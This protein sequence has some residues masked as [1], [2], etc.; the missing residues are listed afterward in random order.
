MQKKILIIGASSGL[1]KRLAEIYAGEGY[2]VGI[3]ARRE[4]LLKEMEKK[5]PGQVNILASDINNEQIVKN[6]IDIIQTM[7][8]IDICIITASVVDFNHEFILSTEEKTVE[9]NVSGYIKVLNTV[10]HYFKNKGEGHIAGVTSIAAARGNKLVPA[11][12]ASKAFQSV[13]LESLRIKAQYEKNN[14]HITEIIPGYIDTAMGKGN[15][16]FWVTSLDKAAML[17]KKA[18][19]KKKDRAFIT[20]RWWWVYKTYRF[21]PS[22]IYNRIVNSGVSFQK[23]KK[24]G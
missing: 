6:L 23:N 22:F 13:Y 16:M 18:I 1:G 8:G 9:T 15:R 11:Y 3:V 7:G 19:E 4:D 20:K 2:L 12:H 24:T 17:T 14:I 21:L 10:W 5:F